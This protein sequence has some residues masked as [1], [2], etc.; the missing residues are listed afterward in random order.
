[1]RE[2]VSRACLRDGI[3][4]GMKEDEPLE[5]LRG[6]AERFGIVEEESVLD[7]AAGPEPSS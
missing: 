7:D 2:E 3:S 5:R 4:G 6:Q 1:M